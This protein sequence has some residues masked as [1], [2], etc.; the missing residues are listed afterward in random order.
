MWAWFVLCR[1]SVFSVTVL[2][3]ERVVV[4]AEQKPG[5][6]DDEVHDLLLVT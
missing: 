4:V 6:T 3:E 1:I 2:R 5:C